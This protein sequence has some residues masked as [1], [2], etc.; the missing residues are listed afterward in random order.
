M[1]RWQAKKSY[2]Y[3]Y[4]SILRNKKLLEEANRDLL[5]VLKQ[6]KGEESRPKPI[7]GF[8]GPDVS[9]VRDKLNISRL[10]R[11]RDALEERVIYL[12]EKIVKLENKKEELWDLAT[13]K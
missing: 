1:K 2:H 10:E 4:K 13:K 6:L 11:S 5:V 3:A 9:T 7:K 8:K 12:S